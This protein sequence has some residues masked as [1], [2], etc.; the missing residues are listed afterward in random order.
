MKLDAEQKNWYRLTSEKAISFKTMKKKVELYLQSCCKVNMS[1]DLIARA[2]PGELCWSIEIFDWN[3][4][5]ALFQT[6]TWK[7]KVLT[8][9]VWHTTCDDGIPE[10]TEDV[11]SN[12]SLEELHI[13]LQEA[14]KDVSIKHLN[15][16]I[17]PEWEDSIDKVLATLSSIRT[18]GII[19]SITQQKINL[20]LEDF[21][22]SLKKVKLFAAGNELDKF[23]RWTL[24]ELEKRI[25][26]AIV[27]LEKI[28]DSYSQ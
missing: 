2:K 7:E 17:I 18:Q 16:A 3:R 13:K 23:R 5:D 19:S 6:I 28:C 24:E 21:N 15:E 14:A 4:I 26:E 20:T 22:D 8:L 27:D 1:A 12:I 11:P 9:E 25:D 10:R